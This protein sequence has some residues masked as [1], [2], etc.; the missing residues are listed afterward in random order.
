MTLI[1]KKVCAF[2]SELLCETISMALKYGN[3]DGQF[4]VTCVFLSHI[5]LLLAQRKKI[6]VTSQQDVVCQ[7]NKIEF[8]GV[9]MRVHSQQHLSW[10]RTKYHLCKKWGAG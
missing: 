1:N 7:K 6:L 9:T 3:S 2:F 8:P 4:W 5:L 10:F